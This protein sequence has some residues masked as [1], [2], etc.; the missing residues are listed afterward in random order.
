MTLTEQVADS[1]NHILEVNQKVND[2]INMVAYSGEEQSKNAEEISRNIEGINNVTQQSSAGTQQIAKAAEE[3]NR[4]TDDLQG[5]INRFKL[6]EEKSKVS[7]SSRSRLAV[8]ENGRM[9]LTN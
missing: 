8:R 5:L 4:L 6:S 9:I 3:L 7:L 1:L 2:M